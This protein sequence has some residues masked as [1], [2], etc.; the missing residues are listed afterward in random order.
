MTRAQILVQSTT[1]ILAIA[2]QQPQNVLTLL[3]R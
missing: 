1:Q 2:N 3:G